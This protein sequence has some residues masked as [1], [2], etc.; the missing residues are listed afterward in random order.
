V[1]DLAGPE[2]ARLDGLTVVLDT[3]VP[4][5]AVALLG[6]VPSAPLNALRGAAAAMVFRAARGGA[7]V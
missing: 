7:P 6:G 2:H 5:D 1:I 4:E 3:G